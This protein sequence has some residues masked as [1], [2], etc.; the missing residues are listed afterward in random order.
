MFSL[1]LQTQLRYSAAAPCK[2]MGITSAIS[3]CRDERKVFEH[4]KRVAATQRFHRF[5]RNPETNF[6]SLNSFQFMVFT[7]FM[8]RKD[9]QL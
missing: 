5:T 7:V 8:S 1:L 2:S 6:K 4:Y 3:Y 9:H